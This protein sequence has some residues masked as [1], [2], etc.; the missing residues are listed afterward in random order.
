MLSDNITSIERKHLASTLG[1]DYGE[2]NTK[3]KRLFYKLTYEEAI[4]LINSDGIGAHKR[5]Y[6]CEVLGLDYKEFNTKL[7]RVE[8]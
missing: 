5:K 7:K 3:I 4:Q 8:V 2:V 6:L 1:I